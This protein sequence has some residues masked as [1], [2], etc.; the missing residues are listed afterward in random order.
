MTF[1]GSSTEDLKY[2]AANTEAVAPTSDGST[3]AIRLGA[4]YNF[5]SPT[6]NSR[7]GV[8]WISSAKACSNV[9]AE[10]PAQTQ[11]ET[12]VTATKNIWNSQLLGRVTT[13]E[14]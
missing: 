5:T 14:V 3:Q 9:N 6:V 11:L 8:S 2:P 12:V 7:V 1:R 13:T 10:I 4:V